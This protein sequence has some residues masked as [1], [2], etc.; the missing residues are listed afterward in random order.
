M[1][2]ELDAVSLVVLSQSSFLPLPVTSVSPGFTLP[3][4]SSQ[5]VEL[6]T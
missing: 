4:A 2:F 3:S 1:L 6:D 5:S